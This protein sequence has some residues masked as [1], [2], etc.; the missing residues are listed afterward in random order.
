VHGRQKQSAQRITLRLLQN[1]LIALI[2]NSVDHSLFK[3]S[4]N[5]AY[6]QIIFD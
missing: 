1:R 3:G 2:I 6:D 4:I 5:G